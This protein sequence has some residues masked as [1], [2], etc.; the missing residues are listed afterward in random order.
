MPIKDALLAEYDH[1]MATTRKLLERIPDGN[2]AW[3]PHEK[4]RSLGD[5]AT[6][7]A[8]LLLWTPLILNE[9]S[10]DLVNSPPNGAGAAARADV[11][12]AFDRSTSRARLC[13]DK[14]D[15][16]LMAPWTLQ[17]DGQQMFTLPRAAAF[18][19]FVLSHVVHHR[20]QLSVYLRLTG[21]PVPAIYGPSADEG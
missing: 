21:V 1:E 2:L 10:F 11:L 18:R 16:E 9:F 6:H 8:S 5:L 13:L 15:A 3:K 17:R 14:T 19:T 20:G 12:S 4:S 7:L